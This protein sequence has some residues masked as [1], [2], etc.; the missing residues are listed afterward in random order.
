[1]KRD[2]LAQ[3]GIS[4]AQIYSTMSQAMNG[5]NVGSLE[6][7]GEDM[8]ILLR[9]SQFRK[10]VNLEDILALPIQM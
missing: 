9:T 10:D 7:T 5:V 6:D 3:Y 8:S 4:P 1:M 2:I